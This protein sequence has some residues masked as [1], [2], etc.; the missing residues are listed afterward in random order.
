MALAV[1]VFLRKRRID[2]GAVR[3]MQDV[4]MGETAKEKTG[5]RLEGASCQCMAKGIMSS[6][7]RRGENDGHSH[8]R[9]DEATKN[10][11]GVVWGISEVDDEV[12]KKEVLITRPE[13]V[14]K[15]A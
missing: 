15:L 4:E 14:L 12:R 3:A 8:S 10:K 7:C 6:N 1:Y 11:E 13:A 5:L 2:R 9:C